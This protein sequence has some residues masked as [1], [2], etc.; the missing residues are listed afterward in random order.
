MARK[1]MIDQKWS[2]LE[3]ASDLEN[4]IY[5]QE[6]DCLSAGRLLSEIDLYPSIG[7]TGLGWSGINLDFSKKHV[8]EHESD[9][10]VPD[11]T[12]YSKLHFSMAS[13]EHLSG[14]V[15]RKNVS[16]HP[17]KGLENLMPVSTVQQFGHE[18]AIGLSKNR[19]SWLFYNLGIIYWRIKGD[20][21]QALECGRRAVH[22]APRWEKA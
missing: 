17:E 5:T 13:F 4:R 21:P 22:Y 2:G 16:S 1:S 19:T 9:Y 7:T 18:I 6:V 12:R 3:G 11:C 20:A 10:L 15:Y 14:M 8:V